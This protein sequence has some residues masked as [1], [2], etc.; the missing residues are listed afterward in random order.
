MGIFQILNSPFT[1]SL[2]QIHIQSLNISKISLQA[3]FLNEIIDASRIQHNFNVFVSRQSKLKKLGAVKE[4]NL[5]RIRQYYYEI[6]RLSKDNSKRL[7]FM[8]Y[9]LSRALVYDVKKCYSYSGK[10]VYN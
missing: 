3:K 1:S 8:Q 5:N 6:K 10:I 2:T 4:F 9:A 7:S